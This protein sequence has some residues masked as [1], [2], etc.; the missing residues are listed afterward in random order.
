MVLVAGGATLSLSIELAFT[1]VCCLLDR[2]KKDS[3][4]IETLEV[5]DAFDLM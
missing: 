5:K 2:R 4:P 1:L 3:S